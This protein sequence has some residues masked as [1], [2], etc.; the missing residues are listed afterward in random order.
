MAND[1]LKQQIERERRSMYICDW[2]LLITLLLGLALLPVYALLALPPVAAKALEAC[3]VIWGV[4]FLF[5]FA[6][7]VG[8]GLLGV[9]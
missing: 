4:L 1:Y 9:H 2:L 6:R 8:W 3:A 7:R 5:H